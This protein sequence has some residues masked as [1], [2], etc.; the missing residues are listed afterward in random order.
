MGK[1]AKRKLLNL[2]KNK[3]D[4]NNNLL[5]AIDM[6]DIQRQHKLLRFNQKEISPNNLPE[7]FNFKGIDILD[8]KY[9]RAGSIYYKFDEPIEIIDSKTKK[10]EYAQ[11]FYKGNGLFFAD[12]SPN[13]WSELAL[14]FG[15]PITKEKHFWEWVQKYPVPIILTRGPLSACSVLSNGQI[16]IGLPSI[17]AG[18]K[19][20]SNS[21]QVKQSLNEHLKLFTKNER[22]FLLA[23]GQYDEKEKSMSTDAQKELAKELSKYNCHLNLLEWNQK[24]TSIDKYL[25]SLSENERKKELDLLVETS[26]L[27]TLN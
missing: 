13:I 25:A 16:G 23:F 7:A 11:I 1:A 19:I 18:T 20:V 12:I 3:V 4:S 27:I 24:Y 10:S 6:L 21:G 26:S 5:Q 9:E 8:P 14:K 17:W 22:L 15:F 2:N